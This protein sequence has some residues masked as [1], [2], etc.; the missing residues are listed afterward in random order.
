MISHSFLTMLR[1]LSMLALVSAANAL[2]ALARPA[3]STHCAAARS[4]HPKALV[5]PELMH[6]PG[7]DMTFLLSALPGLGEGYGG[8][9]AFSQS[10]SGENGEINNV[11]AIGVLFPTLVTAAF[12]KDNILEAFEPD[13]YSE[14][15]LPPGWKQ[16]PS[17]S[18]PGKF[19]FL[20]TATKD[21]YDKLPP[22][23]KKGLM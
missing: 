1:L 3:A 21:R 20:N 23:A 14:S 22:A 13:M 9:S 11:V 10:A 5:P 6:L 15:N 12:F 8:V 18:R 4:G 16:V 17:Q 2:Q 7:G 19:S